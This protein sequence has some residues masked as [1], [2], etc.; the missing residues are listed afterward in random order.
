MRTGDLDAALRLN[1]F[2]TRHF[3]AIIG[4]I[5]IASGVVC[6]S[7]FLIEVERELGTAL[8]IALPAV[9]VVAMGVGYLIRRAWSRHPP[10]DVDIPP[11]TD[12]PLS[13][14]LARRYGGAM[15]FALPVIAACALIGLGANVL[16]TYKILSR[17][18]IDA[19]AIV[20]MWLL[21]IGTGYVMLTPRRLGGLVGKWQHRY[22]S[23]PTWFV[24]WRR[25]FRKPTR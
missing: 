9:G 7:Y 12:A 21:I 20:L 17:G 14:F 13:T 25:T 10:T 18:H 24:R 6:G 15:G 11:G 8:L 1:A 22:L 5:F 19:L 23:I 2:L 16:E 4:S 3:G